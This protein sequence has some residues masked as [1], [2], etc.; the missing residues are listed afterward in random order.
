LEFFPMIFAL[1][2]IALWRIFRR[3]P[4]HAPIL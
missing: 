2:G 3:K 1:G 4:S